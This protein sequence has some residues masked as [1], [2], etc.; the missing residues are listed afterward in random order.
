MLLLQQGPKPERMEKARQGRPIHEGRL[1]YV[2]PRLLL[3][4]SRAIGEV[5]KA[6]FRYPVS[7]LTL[8]PSFQISTN[9]YVEH[10]LVGVRRIVFLLD[11]PQV[12]C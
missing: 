9:P 2:L 12:L 6:Y 3:R 4:V 1:P 5:E 10:H 11:I 8:L 7:F